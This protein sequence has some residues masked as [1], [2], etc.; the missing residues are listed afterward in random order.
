MWGKAALEVS[1]RSLAKRPSD[2]RRTM[3]SFIRGTASQPRSRVR[4]DPLGSTVFADKFAASAGWSFLS[5]PAGRNWPASPAFR[6]YRPLERVEPAFGSVQRR[7]TKTVRRNCLCDARFKT[8][9][10]Y[11]KQKNSF[12]CHAGNVQRSDYG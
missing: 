4:W 12:T 2:Q 1:W 9:Y 10:L 8:H 11:V 7:S 6:H 5:S 3:G